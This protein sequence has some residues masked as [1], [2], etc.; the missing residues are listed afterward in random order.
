MTYKRKSIALLFCGGSSLD[1][2][3]RRGDSVSRETDMAKWM[4]RIGEIQMI[5]QV[6]PHFVFGGA[7]AEV[8]PAQW[9]KLSTRIA[10][11]YPRYDGFLVLHSPETINATSAALSFALQNLDKP[12]VLT[13]SFVPS[14]DER[15]IPS[16]AGTSRREAADVRTNLMNALQVAVSGLDEVAVVFGSRIYRGTQLVKNSPGSAQ[17]FAS[18]DGRLLGKIDF[19]IQLGTGVRPRSRRGFRSFP[20]FDPQILRIDYRPGIPV[21]PLDQVSRSVHGVILVVWESLLLPA[22]L[23][24]V[25]EKFRATGIPVA[26]A[27]PHAVRVP[28]STSDLVMSGLSPTTA[29]VKFLWARGQ[30]ASLRKLR[31]L[32]ARDIAGE[33]APAVGGPI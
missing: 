5:A 30:T 31:E 8:G 24:R 7:G 23:L 19:G 33:F 27:V 15:R 29:V 16:T 17:P 13:G 10:A 9:T 18:F 2:R 4:E 20:S 32:L 25:L 22:T 21:P 14:K 26:V 28:A 11:L 1:P 12:V 3:D 6:D